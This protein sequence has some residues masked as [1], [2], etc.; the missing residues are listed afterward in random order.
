M[1]LADGRVPFSLN[2]LI[3]E[4]KRRAR[5]RRVVLVGALVVVG[6]AAV[7]GVLTLQPTSEPRPL[8]LPEAGPGPILEGTGVICSGS[9]GVWFSPPPV[10]G[11]LPSTMCDGYI[12]LEGFDASRLKA[13]GQP[14]RAGSAN[15]EGVYRNGVLYVVGQGRPFRQGTGAPLA[16]LPCKQ[17][18]GGWPR[19]WVSR[20][21]AARMY[22][23][24]H[25]GDVTAWH[26]FRYVG[27]STFVVAASSTNPARTRHDLEPL[28]PGR[29]CVFRSR[30]SKP[31]VDRWRKQLEA[32]M[33]RLRIN[34]AGGPA[35]LSRLGQPVLEARTLLVTPTLRAWL[36]R[37]P[38][39]LIR[40]IPDLRR[41]GRNR[42]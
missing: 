32:D 19:G 26:Y 42:S 3:A 11:G 7:V 25:Q 6:S 41:V 23:K 28:L 5:Q 12:R 4:A 36:R 10:V 22:A 39:G 38:P 35:L 27:R 17:P 31:V 20:S 37:T 8:T 15:V 1:E 40:V 13:D 34:T 21:V 24:L 18:V 14:Y 30:F 29:V 33:G 16:D 2:R 9:S